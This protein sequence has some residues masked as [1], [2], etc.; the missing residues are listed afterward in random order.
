M[1]RSLTLIGCKCQRDRITDQPPSYTGTNYGLGKFLAEVPR[2]PAVIIRDNTLYL[3]I[4]EFTYA[5]SLGF[6]KLSILALYWRFFSL[7]RIRVPIITLTAA[8]VIWL[9]CRTFL[10]L[11]HCWPVQAFW[12]GKAKYPGAVC[13]IDDAKFEFGTVVVHAF[14]DV[15]IF[16]LPVFQIQQLTFRTTAE[17]L[18]VLAIFA[19]GAFV[20]IVSIVNLTQLYAFLHTEPSMEVLL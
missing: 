3:Y 1:R 2:P 15:T 20:C 9:L 7:F 18:A 8:T 4:L 10:G 11:F 6:S 14:L 16:S 13:P 17:K 12:E 5:Y 19:S